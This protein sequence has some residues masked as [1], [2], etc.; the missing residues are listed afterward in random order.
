MMTLT[1]LMRFHLGKKKKLRAGTRAELASFEASNGDASDGESDTSVV[2]PHRK[3]KKKVSKKKSKNDSQ[4]EM[5]EM[6]GNVKL[7]SGFDLHLA[8]HRELLLKH[9]QDQIHPLMEASVAGRLTASQY[10]VEPTFGSCRG[11]GFSEAIP[12]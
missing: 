5:A 12:T 11:L 9:P 8:D 1:E 2:G 4:V 3:R 6:F 10:G 7:S